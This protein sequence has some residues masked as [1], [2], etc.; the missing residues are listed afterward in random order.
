MKK[1]FQ[2]MGIAVLACG[3]F[4]SCFGD[5]EEVKDGI[6]VTFDDN[7]WD[8]TTILGADLSTVYS[9]VYL[10]AYK[11]ADKIN[12]PSVNGFVPSAPGQTTFNPGT[13]DEMPF[14]FW[15][16]E[17]DNDVDEDGDE[18]WQPQNF[19]ENITAIDLTA[20]TLSG[21]ATGAMKHTTNGKTGVLTINFNNAQWAVASSEKAMKKLAK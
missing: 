10:D 14:V 7:S 1:V 2:L 15:Y 6:K 16:R 4:T 18:N 3:M 12:Q 8:A 5:D 21:E 20:L 17:N 19:T 11:N 13:K 9:A